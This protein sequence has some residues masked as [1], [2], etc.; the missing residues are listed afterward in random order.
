MRKNF[1]SDQ[2]LH[3]FACAIGDTSGKNKSKEKQ[4]K[5]TP[6][7]SLSSSERLTIFSATSASLRTFPA[8]LAYHSTSA[9]F[10]AG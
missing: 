6:S 2:M 3:T 4:H 10:V 5:G 1:I 9:E 8:S 7:V